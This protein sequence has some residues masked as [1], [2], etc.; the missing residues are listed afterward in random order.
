M[1]AHG[2]AEAAEKLRLARLAKRSPI[3]DMIEN[4][5]Y[6]SSHCLTF[7]SGQGRKKNSQPQENDS[8]ECESSLMS[9]KYAALISIV[10]ILL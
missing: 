4:T 5:V 6:V 3:N 10:Y 9:G 2:S 7:W 8:T 1:R